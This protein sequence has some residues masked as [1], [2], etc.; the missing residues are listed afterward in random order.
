MPN[1]RWLLALI[2]RLHRFIYRVSGGRVG[3]NL[4]GSHMLL[5]EHVGRTTGQP[6]STPLRYIDD[7]SRWIVVASNAGD[8][9]APAWWLNLKDKPEAAVQVG[10]EHHRVRAREAD[11]SER[12]RLWPALEASYRHF[13]DYRERTPR[14]IP[15]VIL[16]RSA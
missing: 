10:R 1:I 15:V 5:L 4:A 11:A 2:T 12:E 8:D 9:R 16:E 6:R 13:A 3:A 7:G 14:E